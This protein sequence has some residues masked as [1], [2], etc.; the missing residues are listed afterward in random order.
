MFYRLT[1]TPRLVP[2]FEGDEPDHF[3]KPG[4]P[5]APAPPS[6]NNPPEREIKN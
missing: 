2:T 5:N 1:P 4:A 6:P 3:Q